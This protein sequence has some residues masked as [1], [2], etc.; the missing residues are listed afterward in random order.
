MMNQ[1]TQHVILAPSGAP[2][3]WC[4][5]YSFQSD[6]GL[7]PANG[8]VGNDWY[9]R[10]RDAI[11]TAAIGT[12]RDPDDRRIQDLRYLLLGISAKVMVQGTWEYTDPSRWAH[13]RITYT[14]V[15]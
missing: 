6:D 10:V 12:L 2:R 1:Q 4:A 9:T 15:T 14:Y 8:S 7:E 13:I 5:T 11:M 3:R